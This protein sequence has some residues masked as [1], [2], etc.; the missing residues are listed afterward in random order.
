MLVSRAHQ[1]VVS[2]VQKER[3]QT[4]LAE[5]REFQLKSTIKITMN[6]K[7]IICIVL[8]LAVA[9]PALSGPAAYGICQAGCAGIVVACFS[10]AGFVFGTVPGS[11]IAAVPALTACN[12]AWGTCCAACAAAILL[13]TP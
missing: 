8:F 13:P 2:Q 3:L 12:A 11:Q 9:Q 5:P 7:V 4:K 1:K 10:A 6:M